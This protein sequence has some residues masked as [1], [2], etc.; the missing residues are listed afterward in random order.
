MKLCTLFI[1]FNFAVTV[2]QSNADTPENIEPLVDQICITISNVAGRDSGELKNIGEILEKQIFKYNGW[3]KSETHDYKLRYK[4]FMDLH[5]NEFICKDTLNHHRQHLFKRV[6]DMKVY[7]PV[8]L[9]FFLKEGQEDQHKLDMNAYEVNQDG[10]KETILDYLKGIAGGAIKP[11]QRH[12][13]A[14]IKDMIEIL[15]DEFGA[16]SGAELKP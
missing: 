13:M 9:N 4:Q 5:K 1:A 2:P 10:T 6:V 3:S 14:Q 7:T 11:D 15:E 12:N 16:L 8:L